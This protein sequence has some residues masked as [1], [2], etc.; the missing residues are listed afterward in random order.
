MSNDVISN[1]CLTSKP[2]F[3]LLQGSASPTAFL[4]SGPNLLSKSDQQPSAPAGP[5]T[6]NVKKPQ[7]I[8]ARSLMDWTHELVVID[9][10]PE[11]RREC[12]ALSRE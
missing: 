12:I 11:I 4:T 10:R 1:F 2:T 7:T 8:I 6:A 3:K 5:L 9:R